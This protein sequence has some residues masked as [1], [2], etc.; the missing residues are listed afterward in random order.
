MFMCR[1]R[2]RLKCL[3]LENEKFVKIILEKGI[4][5]F[6]CLLYIK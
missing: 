1:K 5:I 2:E 3:S 6:L 4:L